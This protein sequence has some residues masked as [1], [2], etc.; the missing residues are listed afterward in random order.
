MAATKRFGDG[1]VDSR[2]RIELGRIE[3]LHQLFYRCGRFGFLCGM[4]DGCGS[5]D[6]DGGDG[7]EERPYEYDDAK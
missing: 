1:R 7:G 3:H 2:D 6:G 5:E 4:D